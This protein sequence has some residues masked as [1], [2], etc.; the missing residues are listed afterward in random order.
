MMQEDLDVFYNA[1]EFAS[2]AIYKDSSIAV[3]EIDYIEV[4]SSNQKAITA[5][6]SDVVDLAVGDLIVIENVEYKV[7]NFDTKDFENFEK[8]IIVG[9][10][11]E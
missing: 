8:I 4:M 7:I 1:D 6:S 11:D 10:L 2:S 5:K 9:I 3:V